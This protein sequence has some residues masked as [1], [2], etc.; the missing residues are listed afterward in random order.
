LFVAWRWQWWQRWKRTA[1]TPSPRYSLSLTHTPLSLVG[2]CRSVEGTAGKGDFSPISDSAEPFVQ[3]TFTEFG[4]YQ[5]VAK[6]VD[7]DGEVTESALSFTVDAKV[8]RELLGGSGGG[9][10][11]RVVRLGE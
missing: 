3:H 4:K 6:V 8:Q 1:R 7:K 5:V 10:A 2:C 9:G 11:Q